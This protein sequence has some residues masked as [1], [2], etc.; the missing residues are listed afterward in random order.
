MQ[1]ALALTEEELRQVLSEAVF[2]KSY[3]FQLDLVGDGECTLKIP[4]QETIARPG[5]LVSG[6]VL[7][8]AADVAMWLAIMTKLGRTD[9]VTVEMKTSFL[10]VAKQEDVYCTAKIL[11]LGSRLI[12]GVVECVNST[13]KLLTHHT[14]TYMRLDTPN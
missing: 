5:H 2:V 7:M 6:P 14:L 3:G 13:R 4:F 1:P 11:K 10:N 9:V 12:Y 8:A